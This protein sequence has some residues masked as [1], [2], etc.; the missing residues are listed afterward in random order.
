MLFGQHGA[1]ATPHFTQVRKPVVVVGPQTSVESVHP[2]LLVVVAAQ[3]AWP[4]APHFMHDRAPVL[5]FEMQLSV[6]SAH[7]APV[8][9]QASPSL[10]H[11]HTP[12]AHVPLKPVVA[13]TQLDLA[14]THRLDEQH[15]PESVQVFPAQHGLPTTPQGRHTLLEESH[16]EVASVH[17]A[18]LVQHGCPGPPHFKHW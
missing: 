9:Q 1:P 15:A 17:F 16:A 13:I 10:P 4:S 5:V 8:L 2:V 3:Q 18:P 12:A 7:A 14:A 11:S 6:G